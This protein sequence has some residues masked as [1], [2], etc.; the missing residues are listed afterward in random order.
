MK[1]NT[2]KQTAELAIHNAHKHAAKASMRSSADICIVDAEQCLD[3]GQFQYA[4]DW[5]VR[6]LGYSVGVFNAKSVAQ[7][8]R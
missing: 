2:T 8:A 5:A 3:A 4:F 6:S 7:E 1:T